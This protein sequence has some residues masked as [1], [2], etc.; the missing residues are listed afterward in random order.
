MMRNLDCCASRLHTSILNWTEVYALRD[1]EVKASAGSD[2]FEPYER[3][4][5]K[6]GLSQDAFFR[7]LRAKRGITTR[8]L[9]QS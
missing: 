7:F 1:A 9:T 2:S 8:Q 4:E 6:V 5:V 3:F